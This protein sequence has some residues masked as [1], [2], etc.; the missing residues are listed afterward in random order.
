MLPKLRGKRVVIP[1]AYQ[2]VE[3]I[4]GIERRR[5][6]SGEEK[7]RLV[8]EAF[9]P[10]VSV[11]AFARRQG[12]CPSLL[13]R[14]RRRMPCSPAMPPMSDAA[15]GFVPVATVIRSLLGHWDGLCALL[16]DGCIEIDS[17]TVE[18]LHRVVATTRKNSL[19]AGADAGA[20]SWA[21]FTSLIQTAK[22]N[23]LDPFAYLKDV[24]ERMVSGALKAHEL[25][26]LLPWVWKA[27]RAAAA[28]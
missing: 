17:N 7:Q 5:R 15:P 12:L 6:Y 26:R 27:E 28:P 25:H 19:F 20:R 21:I 22:L 3:V 8:E 4:T 2:R 16:E 23:G 13:Y 9:R 14:W 11:T 1:M 10:G 24:L 18:R